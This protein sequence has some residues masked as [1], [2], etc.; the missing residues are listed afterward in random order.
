MKSRPSKPPSPGDEST[1]VARRAKRQP[2]AKSK[3]VSLL[4][5]REH[6]QVELRA[7]LLQRGYPEQEVQEAIDWVARHKFQSEER[8]I[9]SLHRRRA[10]TFGDRAI[11]AELSQHGLNTHSKKFPEAGEVST[12]EVLAEELTPEVDRAKAW[13]LRRHHA[14]LAKLYC[15][16][17]KPDS[18]ELLVIKAKVFRG[19]ASRGFE[20][21]NID[22]A[23]RQV[24]SDMQEDA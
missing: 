22:R 20:F 6:S 13:I 19:L 24:I 7:K 18:A 11:E 21:G 3:A 2:S 15:P 16:E 17:G 1:G 12:V 14:A 10:S 23:W 5:R 8:F 9:V 4:G